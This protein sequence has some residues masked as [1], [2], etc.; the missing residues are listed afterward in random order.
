MWSPPAT[1]A[2]PSPEKLGLSLARWCTCSNY[3]G[4]AIDHAA[5]AGFRSV[6]LVGHLGKLIKVS[7]GCMNTHSKVADARRETLAAHAALAGETGR[8]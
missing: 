7:A 5:G 8:W 3:I 2:R 6:L 1:T 4:A